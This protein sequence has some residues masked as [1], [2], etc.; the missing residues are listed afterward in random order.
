MGFLSGLFKPKKLETKLGKENRENF[1]QKNLGSSKMQ[2]QD[3]YDIR[4][5]GIVVVGKI[6]E[7]TLVPGQTGTVNGKTTT[8]KT[9]EAHHKRLNEAKTGENIGVALSNV[10]KQDFQKGME[11][12]FT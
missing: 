6:I 10:K 4:G 12:E 2:V 5:V 3:A 7:G 9:I 8:V 1:L 11:I